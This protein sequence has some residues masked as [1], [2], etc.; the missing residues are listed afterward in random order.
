M[1]INNQIVK[2]VG[3]SKYQTYMVDKRGNVYTVSK[4]TGSIRKMAIYTSPN[5]YKMLTRR[6]NGKYTTMYVHRM[7]AQAFIEKPEGATMVDH[8]D[9]NR[10]NNVV[11]NLRWVNRKIN[12]STK[13]AREMKSKNHAGVSHKG[14]VLKITTPDGITK[15]YE[16]AK[17]AARELNCSKNFIYI[18]V[19]HFNGHTKRFDAEFV[20]YEK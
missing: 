5:G 2:E 11:E 8:V 13:H 4:K 6:E 10:G 9:S 14:Q 17:D 18:V 16:K 20:N 3:S 7:V 19:K 12:N 15:F 1:K